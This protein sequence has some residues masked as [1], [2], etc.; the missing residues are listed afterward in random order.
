[1]SLVGALRLL[2]V[3]RLYLARPLAVRPLPAL[4]ESFSPLPTDSDGL[5]F[6]DTVIDLH[7]E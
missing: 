2:P 4:T 7:Q 6:L 3:A 1:L 5:S